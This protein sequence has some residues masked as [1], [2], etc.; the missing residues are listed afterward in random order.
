MICFM[1]GEKT[2]SFLGVKDG[3][4]VFRCMSCSVIYV[5][6]FLVHDYLNFYREGMYTKKH[7]ERKGVTPYDERYS[8]DR[9]VAALRI[10]GENG[11]YKYISP[12]KNKKFIDIG[13]SNGAFV[14]AIH[15]YGG[16]CDY[17]DPCDYMRSWVRMFS[18]N[19]FNVYKSIEDVP[20]YTY[21]VVT[22]WDSF[23]HFVD[24][25]GALITANKILK[26][27]NG[28]VVIE[29]PN[30]ECVAAK[31][32][33][34]NWKHVKPKEHLYLFSKR[35]IEKLFSLSGFFILAYKEF[36]GDRMQVIGAKEQ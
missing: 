14:D 1:C 28:Y 6:A 11:I 30:S 31:N 34:I 16:F 26:K 4:N 8:H 27:R 9:N 21:D 2:V 20:E 36:L 17:V 24:P 25:L 5:G 7:Q 15:D 23:E 33:G 19:K 18:K 3:K 29:Q 35:N 12:I 10:M 13:A 32:M 22:F